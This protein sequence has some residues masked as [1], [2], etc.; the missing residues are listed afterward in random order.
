MILQI[1]NSLVNLNTAKAISS[2]ANINTL[3]SSNLFDQIIP[4][5]KI[6][7][8]ELLFTGEILLQPKN[9]ISISQIIT[10]VNNEISVKSNT[11]YNT[12]VMNVLNWDSL[13]VYANKIYESGLVEYSHPNFIAPIERTSDNLYELQFYLNNPLND[14]DINAKEA[15]EIAFNQLPVRVAVIDDGV[16][17]HEDMGNRVLEGFTASISEANPDTKGRPNANDPPANILFGGNFGHGQAC[18]GIIAAEHNNIGIKGIAPSSLIIPINIFNDWYVASHPYYGQYIA[19]RES[20]NDI[21]NSID[22]AWDLFQADVLSN[23]W[24]YN[25]TNN[26]N[27]DAIISAINRARTQGRGGLGAIVVF[28]SGNSHQSFSGVTFPANVNGVITVGA[29]NRN[30][31][32]WN[33]SSR[34]SEMDLVAPSGECNL[35]GDITTIDRMNNKGYETGNYTNR[36]GGTSAACPQIAGVVSLMLSINPGLTE[37]QVK[38]ILQLTARDLGSAGFDN[39]YGLVDAYAAVQMAKCYNGEDILAKNINTNTNV[40]TNAF[41]SGTI[42]IK[43]GNTLTV[44]STLS[45]APEAKIIVEPNAKL[46][47]NGGTITSA[48]PNEFWGA[49][50]VMGNK[51]QPQT[52]QYQGYVELNNAII[53]NATNAISTWYPDNWNTTGGIIKANNTTFRNNLRSVEFMSYHNLNPSGNEMPNQSYF[54]NCTFVWDENLFANDKTELSHVTMWDVN[55]VKFTKCYFSKAD[56][57]DEDNTILTHGIVSEL[58][59]FNVSGLFNSHKILEKSKFS[60]LT[61]G[62]RAGNLENKT[63]RVTSSVFD[64]N[65]CGVFSSWTNNFN[66]TGCDFNIRPDYE[67]FVNPNVDYIKTAAI[68]IFSDFSTRYKI[69]N[70]NFY[71]LSFPMYSV[72]PG[73]TVGVGIRNSGEDP[74]AV[75]N[76]TFV[77]LYGGSQALGKNRSE[78]DKVKVGLKYY[79][80]NFENSMYGLYVTKYNTNDPNI[81]GICEEQRTLS[82]PALNF[83]KDNMTDI[84]NKNCPKIFY[85]YSSNISN[86]NPTLCNTNVIPIDIQTEENNCGIIGD[87]TTREDWYTYKEALESQYVLLLYNYNN[88]LDGGQKDVLLDK[89]SDGWDGDVW[90]LREEYLKASPYL[91]VEVLKEMVQSEKLPLAV[92][93]EI[94]LSN[95]EA[96]QKDEFKEFI[97]NEQTYL[98]PLAVSLIEESWENKTF[99]ASVESNLSDKFTELENAS[100]SIIDIILNDTTGINI[101]EYRGILSEMRSTTSKFELADSYIG[102]QEYSSARNVLINLQENENYAEEI[103]DYLQYTNEVEKVENPYLLS[104][105]VLSDLA[106]HNTIVGRKA[107]SMLY[108]KGINTD[109][110]P[111]VLNMEDDPEEKSVRIKGSLSDLASIAITISPNPAKDYISLTYD[112]PTKQIYTL[113]IY[114]NK[115]IELFAK[116]LN[117]NKGMQTID[118]K[119]FSSGLYYYNVTNNKG[120]IK[121]DKLIIVK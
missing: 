52:E 40:N 76:N 6:G 87:R 46:I 51:N 61:Y 81:Y 31:T 29:I 4:I 78:N 55:G 69:A 37:T 12:Y 101:N 35:Q 14:I 117:G 86:T 23:S 53:E 103:N 111:I 70:N 75:N 3:K 88:L 47:V 19:N 41:A 21:A 54:T 107:K 9:N 91:S 11:T 42:T 100:R 20:T 17:T 118:L 104:Q 72:P 25:S 90:A 39:T 94:L 49:I 96:T 45:L 33:Y 84:C 108:F 80:N 83:F 58:S 97:Y 5:K 65:F 89:L 24:G 95:P 62:V 63:F 48:C 121:S 98:T 114:D 57:Y 67:P 82:V 44:T 7:E 16:E 92:C 68:G 99:R 36:F 77:N 116:T 15:W 119:N 8:S 2:Y 59:G 109:Y 110:H 30:G 27:V 120:I 34:G 85:S 64:T 26:L 79:C 105:E 22:K 43:S 50:F 13:F 115:G 28:A 74:N 93:T 106:E 18:S 102:K 38:N 1:A 71:G 113:K 32:I 10:L 56:E 66:V 60:N 73:N 112:L